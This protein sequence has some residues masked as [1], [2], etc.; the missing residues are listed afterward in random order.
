MEHGIC[1][2]LF[3]KGGHSFRR[4]NC[5]REFPTQRRAATEKSLPH[6]PLRLFTRDRHLLFHLVSWRLFPSCSG[7]SVRHSGVHDF[8]WTRDVTLEGWTVRVVLLQE[9][10]H[11]GAKHDAVLCSSPLAR[12]ATDVTRRIRAVAT[13]VADV[14]DHW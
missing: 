4:L 10:S 12:P 9:I 7:H 8:R 6:P 2:K 13:H 11:V 1:F 3:T 14:D 5:H